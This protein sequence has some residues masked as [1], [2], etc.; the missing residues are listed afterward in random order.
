M[1]GLTWRNYGGYAFAYIRALATRPRLPSAQ[2]ASDAAAGG[3]P[4]VSW[5]YA[6][7][8]LSEH[9]LENVTRGMQWTADQVRAI[10]RGG[11]WPHTVIFVTWNDWAGWYDRVT[12]PEVERWT[13]GTQFRYGSA[14]ADGMTDCFDFS[15]TP[16]PPP[17]AP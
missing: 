16:L 17:T 1:A 8:G 13:D 3:L 5:A 6:A 2:F 10:V 14:A 11:L 15:Q 4:A 12:P 7:S 9:T